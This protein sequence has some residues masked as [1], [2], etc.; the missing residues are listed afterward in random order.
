VCGRKVPK[1]EVIIFVVCFN[2]IFRTNYQN[3][4]VR[5]PKSASYPGT[6]D[7]FASVITGSLIQSDSLLIAMD[8]AV[9]FISID[10]RTTLATFTI[11]RM[12]FSLKRFN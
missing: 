2:P 4:I 7:A 8:R 6:G 9:Q 5:L 10:V 3:K 12:E 1:L 11:Q